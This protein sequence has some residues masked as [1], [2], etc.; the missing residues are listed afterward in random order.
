MMALILAGGQ[1]KRL[2]KISGD[3]PKPMVPIGDRPF[4]EYLILFL[5]QHGIKKIILSVGFKASAI[6][7]CFGN[8]KEFGV[9]LL[10]SLEKEPLGTGGA[11]KKASGLIKEY[12]V[13]VL[14]GDSIF[15]LDLLKFL[16]FHRDRGAQAS[17]ALTQNK[18]TGRFGT[19]SLD[20]KKRILSFTEKKPGKKKLINAGIYL[21]SKD[22][23]TKIPK[24]KVSLEKQVFPHLERE[25]FF[26]YPQEG[27]FADIGTP[28][29]YAQ[30]NQKPERLLRCAKLIT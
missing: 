5:K 12:P 9:H 7:S 20:R 17:I 14:N 18:Q 21:L 10:Y 30:I 2:R 8:G 11:I 6:R 25:K 15:E 13:I 4:L 19:V 29:S 3:L 22:V 27:F 24:G 16:S 1:G 28:E 23:I 26:G